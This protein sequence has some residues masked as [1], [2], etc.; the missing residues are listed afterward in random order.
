MRTSVFLAAAV[1]F[2]GAVG[3][4]KQGK[5]RAGFSKEDKAYA[6]TLGTFLISEQAFGPFEPYEVVTEEKLREVF[7]HGERITLWD[8]QAIIQRSSSSSQSVV[9]LKF[10]A[11]GQFVAATCYSLA[12]QAT[13]GAG[14]GSEYAQ[15]RKASPNGPCVFGSDE[16]VADG[17]SRRDAQCQP[18]V[19]SKIRFEL[20]LDGD[21]AKS[22]EKELIGRNV[23]AMH[24]F[25]DDVAASRGANFDY[26][27]L[28]SK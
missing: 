11:E 1:L 20:P 17:P 12:C 28:H 24:W 26:R 27:R 10:N 5:L 6:K 15:F 2:V 3:C 8:S 16:A 25:A 14:V 19:S 18:T 21:R 13:I 23:A 4:G 9:N 22:S 7:S